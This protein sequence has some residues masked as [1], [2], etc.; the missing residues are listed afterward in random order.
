M[1]KKALAAGLICGS[2][3]ILIF[4][5]QPTLLM[6]LP[7]S[8]VDILNAIASSLI[9]ATIF[10]TTLEIFNRN[11]LLGSVREYLQRA[12][13]DI[14]QA[15]FSKTLS[16][17]ITEEIFC[18]VD[19]FI[20]RTPYLLRNMKVSL[21]FQ[22]AEPGYLKLI[23][24]TSFT[25]EN[26]TAAPIKDE[27]PAYENSELSGEYTAY[28]KLTKFQ[29]GGEQKL[30]EMVSQ[31]KINSSDGRLT[32]LIPIELAPGG[33]SEIVFTVE[34]IVRRSDSDIW[35]VTYK[36]SNLSIVCVAPTEL[37]VSAYAIHPDVQ[38][39][40]AT[41]SGVTLKRWDIQCGILPFQGIQ[42]SWKE[43]A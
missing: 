20:I 36:T 11:E 9:V 12:V 6:Y 15:E 13:E 43:S 42:L 10:M 25:V 5:L 37:E 38:H 24:T 19:Q 3:G 29:V 23:D 26:L 40:K 31:S 41:P 27:L 14:R 2:L 18:Q 34:K 8:F 30:E 39:F 4:V 7:N 21:E 32:I 33:T 28:P 1:T 17:R 35:N 22:L 16:D